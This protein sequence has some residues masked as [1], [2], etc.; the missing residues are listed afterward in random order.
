MGAV[1]QVLILVC[2][3]EN[4]SPSGSQT[5]KHVCSHIV[6]SFSLWYNT[7]TRQP[8]GF[9]ARLQATVVSE[10]LGE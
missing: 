9:S 7:S 6:I 5:I 10:W 8:F 2:N 4:N 3:L 1:E